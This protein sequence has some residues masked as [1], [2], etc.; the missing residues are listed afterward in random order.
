MQPDSRCLFVETLVMSVALFV[1]AAAVAADAGGVNSH[2]VLRMTRHM[3]MVQ[4]PDTG[5]RVVV[6]EDG[7]V[8]IH[9]PA[10]MKRAGDYRLELSGTELEALV[11]DT[12]A[13]GLQEFDPAL[14]REELAY[15]VA[16]SND[17]GRLVS[18]ETDR[19]FTVIEY[20]LPG[21]E[22]KGTLEGNVRW[23]GLQSS[24]RRHP[25]VNALQGLARIERR[26]LDL[27]GD[28]RVARVG[29]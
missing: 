26:L 4:G 15:K 19:G 12:I 3:G 23:R 10:F 13:N 24:A 29:Q 20:R 14:V 6:W 1:S 22:N 17:A 21:V 8:D 16:P 9:Y 7:V 2:M 18:L 25:D 5:P 28:P 27:A 11:A